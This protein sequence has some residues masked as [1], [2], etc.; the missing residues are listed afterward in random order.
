MLYQLIVTISTTTG[1]FTGGLR[2]GVPPRCGHFCMSRFEAV[3]AHRRGRHVGAAAYDPNTDILASRRRLLLGG[4]FGSSTAA[5]VIVGR[6]I[7][8]VIATVSGSNHQVCRG[9]RQCR[10]IQTTTI[11]LCK[12]IGIRK[13]ILQ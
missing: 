2:I 13:L 9:C 5:T 7:V 8:F 3:T 11:A 10:R 1:T 6:R 4:V 12:K